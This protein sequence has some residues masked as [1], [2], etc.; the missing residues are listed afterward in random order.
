MQNE[1]LLPISK[2]YWVPTAAEI[3]LLAAKTNY[4]HRSY[5]EKRMFG[6]WATTQATINADIK[7][8]NENKKKQRDEIISRGGDTRKL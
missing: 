1:P 2:D 6:A 7:T 4:I 8:R 3:A 5:M